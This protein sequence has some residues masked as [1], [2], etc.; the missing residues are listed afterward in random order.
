MV[1]TIFGNIVGEGIISQGD[2]FVVTIGNDP[3]GQHHLL[4]ACSRQVDL[5]ILH[6]L[7]GVQV[8]LR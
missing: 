3:H 6:L 2:C 7:K 4:L 1:I 8:A 5:S